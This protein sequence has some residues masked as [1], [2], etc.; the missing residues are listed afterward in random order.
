MTH[1]LVQHLHV[2]LVGKGHA[3]GSAGLTTL[4][5]RH[6]QRQSG[7][8]TGGVSGC[9]RIKRN[10][11]QRRQGV[12]SWSAWDGH[13]FEGALARFAPRRNGDFVFDFGV[14]NLK[15]CWPS[16]LRLSQELQISV[17]SKCDFDGDR[18]VGG[19]AV[20][21]YA[22]FD[23][24]VG[25]S[26][27]RVDRCRFGQGKH[28]NFY[29]VAG[30]SYFAA[31]E[32]IDAQIPVQI[33]VFEQHFSRLLW[34][35]HDLSYSCNVVTFAI[36]ELRLPACLGTL[37]RF[38]PE[39]FKL[40][41]VIGANVQIVVSVVNLVR[42]NQRLSEINRALVWLDG[43]H[44][45]FLNSPGFLTHGLVAA[46]CFVARFNENPNRVAL[47]GSFVRLPGQTR[48]LDFLGCCDH[49]TI[50]VPLLTGRHTVDPL[51]AG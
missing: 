44:Q 50:C 3:R 24:Q 1:I 31:I 48:N 40:R 39:S 45:V 22:L 23:C 37:D 14:K 17:A 2:L 13:K 49:V 42:Q 33:E 5:F 51:R 38:F 7:R 28:L 27:Q 20:F 29:G 6:M 46:G 10:S 18:L 34:E 43:R 30:C 11:F 8:A 21:G 35:G 16:Q 25:K 12:V 47:H 4:I 32:K 41:N 26:S 19:Y 36:D 15:F 9:Q